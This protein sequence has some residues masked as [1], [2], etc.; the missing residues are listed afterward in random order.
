MNLPGPAPTYFTGVVCVQ[1]FD[2]L[3]DC[4]SIVALTVAVTA[5][6]LDLVILLGFYRDPTQGAGT[7]GRICRRCGSLVLD[8]DGTRRR[9]HC[10]CRAVDFVCGDA[11]GD[12]RR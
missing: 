12:T 8:H 4:L 3:N 6:V 1:P 11:A 5:I 9:F 10:A 7:V 2:L